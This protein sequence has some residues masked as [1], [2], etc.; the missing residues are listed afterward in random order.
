MNTWIDLPILAIEDALNVATAEEIQISISDPFQLV[1]LNFTVSWESMETE[2]GEW[3][4][5]RSSI[6]TTENLGMDELSVGEQEANT[7]NTSTD[8]DSIGVSDPTIDDISLLL[9][10]KPA[11]KIAE[12]DIRFEVDKRSLKLQRS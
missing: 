6:R 7:S 9:A 2:I 5:H 12:T 11:E 1:G 4:F 10:E 8:F 3:K